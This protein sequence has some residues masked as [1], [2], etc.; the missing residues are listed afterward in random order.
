MQQLHQKKIFLIPHAHVDR[1]IGRDGMYPQHKI[2]KPFLN[3]ENTSGQSPGPQ[4]QV[5]AL[6]SK[7]VL[8]WH[9]GKG[10]VP[11]PH[12]KN[13]NVKPAM[14]LPP[15]NQSFHAAVP[16]RG[17]QGMSGKQQRKPTPTI[18]TTHLRT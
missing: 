7:A 18:C 13:P 1:E 3:T 2:R 5:L 17:K 16:F 4:V 9:L 15:T 11:S 10:K 6:Q 8:F 12:L 14:D